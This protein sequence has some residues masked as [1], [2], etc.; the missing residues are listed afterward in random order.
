MKHTYLG[1]RG[2]GG[3]PLPS[4][5]RCSQLL[6]EHTKS[7]G[8]AWWWSNSTYQKSIR[9]SLLQPKTHRPV[10]KSYSQMHFLL[11][12][13]HLLSTCKGNRKESLQ[14]TYPKGEHAM[15]QMFLVILTRTSLGLLASELELCWQLANISTIL[16]LNFIPSSL[17]QN[18]IFF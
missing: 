11:K 13:R 8:L 12:E 16:S 14:R 15:V 9:P 7:R 4:R 5:N 1:M 10:R 6:A 17:N 18:L 2:E 3:G